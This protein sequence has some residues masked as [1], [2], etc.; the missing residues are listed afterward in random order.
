MTSVRSPMR[1][2]CQV[3]HLVQ[4]EYSLFLPILYGVTDSKSCI[5]ALIAL[6]L[7]PMSLAL[8]SSARKATSRIVKPRADS[9][10]SSSSSSNSSLLPVINMPRYVQSPTSS[11]SS[12]Y[13]SLLLLQDSLEAPM[14]GVP[15]TRDTGAERFTGRATVAEY[16]SDMTSATRQVHTNRNG[17]VTRSTVHGKLK[18]SS[19]GDALSITTTASAWSTIADDGV[20]DAGMSRVSSQQ[21][22]VSYPSTGAT[23]PPSEFG[24]SGSNISSMLCRDQ[25]MLFQR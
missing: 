21:T 5:V 7:L 9:R 14:Y 2:H 8:L 25:V 11:Y 22:A 15:L 3:R 19:T 24:S 13:S 1:V 23:T 20:F 16:H 18:H 12:S 6:I 4:G 17:H 10:R